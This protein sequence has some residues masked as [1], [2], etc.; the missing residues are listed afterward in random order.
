MSSNSP[1]YQ[2]SPPR[3]WPFKPSTIKNII[4]PDTRAARKVSSNLGSQGNRVAA[5][6]SG[7]SALFTTFFSRPLSSFPS[8]FDSPNDYID[9]SLV[10]EGDDFEE[11]DAIVHSSSSTSSR[12]PSEIT[13]E[14]K[15]PHKP[16]PVTPKTTRSNIKLFPKTPG[17]NRIIGIK[18]ISNHFF[19]NQRLVLICRMPNLTQT[20][21]KERTIWVG[22]DELLPQDP[23]ALSIVLK[24]VKDLKVKNPS[25]YKILSRYLP[26]HIIPPSS[27]KQ[28]SD[29]SF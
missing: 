11:I 5:E 1:N 24:Y 27:Y 4:D 23:F 8:I 3:I 12:K 10:H 2:N 7:P 6:Q 26:E 22:L 15:I 25:K 19:K 17:K 20:K 28:G 18:T 9:A 29:I 13:F 21:L 14:K 16:A